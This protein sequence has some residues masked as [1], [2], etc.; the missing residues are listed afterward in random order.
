MKLKQNSE[1]QNA[2]GGPEGWNGR[3]E[4][5]ELPSLCASLDDFCL[6]WLDT[7]LLYFITCRNFFLQLDWIILI[8]RQ[9]WTLQ[10]IATGIDI[11]ICQGANVPIA[12]LPLHPRSRVASSWDFIPLGKNGFN[13]F[14]QTQACIVKCVLSYKCTYQPT[15]KF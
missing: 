4:W 15:T 5:L 3:P 6:G 11:A 8:R 13:W 2:R 14:I 9:P 12:W 10:I 1:T 7:Y